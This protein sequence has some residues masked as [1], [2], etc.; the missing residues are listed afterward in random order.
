MTG[1]GERTVYDRNSTKHSIG[2][3][4]TYF[5]PEGACKAVLH[6]ASCY[7]ILFNF[8]RHNDG[9]KLPSSL[10]HQW[11]AERKEQYIIET[12]QNII[13]AQFS[14]TPKGVCKTVVHFAGFYN[15]QLNFGSHNDGC[16]LPSSLPHDHEWQS[17][18]KE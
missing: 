3:I 14:Y 13:V 9:C 8:G 12:Q 10:P 4:L 1:L 18:W 5:T 11:L 15:I 17:E 2:A 16:K 7:N 6:F